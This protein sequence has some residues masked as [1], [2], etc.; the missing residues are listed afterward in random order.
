MG[1]TSTETA[2]I[3]SGSGG[4]VEPAAAVSAASTPARE[5]GARVRFIGD[6]IGY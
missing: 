1:A 5:R 2:K 4:R 3:G 6:E